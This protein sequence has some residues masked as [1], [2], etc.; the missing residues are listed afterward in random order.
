MAK[1]IG[2]RFVEAIPVVLLASLL[3]FAILHLIP[4]DPVDAMMGAAAFGVGTPEQ[5]IALAEQIRDD[6]GLNDPLAIQYVRWLGNA[7]RGDL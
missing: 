2:Q 6:L 4:G 5:R 7:V 3:V 1:F